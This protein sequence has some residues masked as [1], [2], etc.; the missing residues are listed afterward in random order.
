[1]HAK[2]KYNYP[3]ILRLKISFLPL[4]FYYSRIVDYNLRNRKTL[5]EQRKNNFVISDFDENVH[6]EYVSSEFL[7][8]LTPMEKIPVDELGED[9]Q[10]E[11][12]E[13][14]PR[15]ISTYR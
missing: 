1:M 7:P 5:M 13:I 3:I 2:R 12:K 14:K 9:H 8:M 10:V 6:F 4:N 11:R 15:R